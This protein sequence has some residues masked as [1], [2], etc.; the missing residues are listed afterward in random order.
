MSKYIR[1][2]DGRIIPL[3]DEDKETKLPKR[4][5]RF[6]Y[7]QPNNV[8]AFIDK[9]EIIKQADTIEEL[10]DEF[11]VFKQDK[12]YICWFDEQCD[13]FNVEYDGDCKFFK[14]EDCDKVYAAIWTEWGLRYVAN[15]T[16]KGELCLL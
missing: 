1:T 5:L 2:R 10:C 13:D 7:I 14:K 11:V 3:L 12:K 15:M 9:N 4:D 6:Y 16:S 8:I